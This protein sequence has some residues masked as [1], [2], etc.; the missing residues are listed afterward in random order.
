M[1]RLRQFALAA[2]DAIGRAVEHWAAELARA[3]PARF[4]RALTGVPE[5]HRVSASQL[6]DSGGAAEYLPPESAVV[7]QIPQD[8]LLHRFV[9]LPPTTRRRALAMTALQLPREVPLRDDLVRAG[10]VVDNGKR[11]VREASIAVVKRPALESTLVSAADR[12]LTLVGVSD[13]AGNLL[14][15]MLSPRERRPWLR[16][17]LWSV[18]S[19]VGLVALAV[20]L[21]HGAALRLERDAAAMERE[22]LAL[23]EDLAPVIASRNDVDR[24]A[25]RVAVAETVRGGHGLLDVLLRLTTYSPDDVWVEELSVSDQGLRIVGWAA[26]TAEWVLTLQSEG[27]FESVEIGTVSNAAQDTES[28][29]FELRVRP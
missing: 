21:L 1:P 3:M 5:V 17:L 12:G 20:A 25:A 27:V 24:Q 6:A 10:I 18:A 4:V 29:R 28:E 11:E 13:V 8:M 9:T 2:L 19:R 14:H 7:V 23:R 26:S 15:G 16:R 22:A